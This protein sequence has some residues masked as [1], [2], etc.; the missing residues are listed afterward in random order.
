MQKK[1]K[2]R[3]NFTSQNKKTPW[4]ELGSNKDTVKKMATEGIL[5]LK[6]M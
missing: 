6:I 3:C 4:T 5:I 1:K 2:T